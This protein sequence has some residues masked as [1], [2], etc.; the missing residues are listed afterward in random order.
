MSETVFISVQPLIGLQFPLVKLILGSSTQ[1]LL[2]RVADV[3]ALDFVVDNV[4]FLI[5]EFIDKV[6]Q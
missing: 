4:V 2:L 6:R 3:I 5:M 1:S